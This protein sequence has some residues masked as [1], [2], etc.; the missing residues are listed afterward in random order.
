MTVTASIVIRINILFLLLMI[1]YIGYADDPTI[2]VSPSKSVALPGEEIAITVFVL[3]S[4]GKTIR[5]PT[6]DRTDNYSTCPHMIDAESFV[7]SGKEI[8]EMGYPSLHVSENHGRREISLDFFK[9][10]EYRFK[11]KCP[12]RFSL[13]KLKVSLWID[14]KSQGGETSILRERG[15]DNSG[16]QW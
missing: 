8:L 12:A 11:W 10:A 16:N 13:L 15:E 5:I 2:I 14:G 9:S 3:N 6:V 1:P 7:L 4:T